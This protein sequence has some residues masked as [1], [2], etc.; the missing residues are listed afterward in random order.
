MNS[1]TARNENK[2]VPIIPRTKRKD[3][4]RVSVSFFVFADTAAC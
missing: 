3:G 2:M 4:L 1:D